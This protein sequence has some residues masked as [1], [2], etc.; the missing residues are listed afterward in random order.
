[1]V[2]QDIVV[3]KT[4]PAADKGRGDSFGWLLGI[5]NDD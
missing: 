1:M 4:P 5:G 3:F 2:R